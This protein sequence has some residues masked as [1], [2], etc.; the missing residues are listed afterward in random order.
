MNRDAKTSA[1]LVALARTRRMQRAVAHAYLH[2]D[3]PSQTIRGSLGFLLGT[4]RTAQDARAHGDRM[5]ILGVDRDADVAY[6]IEQPALASDQ[7]SAAVPIVYRLYLSGARAG[8]VVPMRAWY[9]AD[10]DEAAIRERVATL[11]PMLAPVM[12][13]TTEAWMLSTRVVHRR[14]LRVGAD[15]QPIR[16]F[17]LQLRVEPVSGTGPLGY[18]TVTSYLTPNAELIEVST[19]PGNSDLA[20]ARVRYAGIASGLGV[21][22]ETCL[23]LVG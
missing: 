20:I 2:R 14:A 12:R 19:I 16:K 10:V 4:S 7:R 11:M 5:Q 6:V 22:K 21:S 9:E 17:A 15:A 3:A 13:A 1:A 8:H 18:T 23:L